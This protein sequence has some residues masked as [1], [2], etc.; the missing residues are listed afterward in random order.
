MVRSVLS[1]IALFGVLT[2][3]G[4][5]L[6]EKATLNDIVVG[7]HRGHVPHGKAESSGPTRGY[8][9]RYHRLELTIDPAIREISGTVTTWF[10]AVE[11]IQDVAFDL[12][13]ELEVA[14][15]LHHGN[16]LSFNRADHVLTVQLPGLL[17]EG[18]LDSLT[19]EYAGVPPETGF[20]SFVQTDHAG[21][22]VIWTLSEPYG[23]RDWW[24]CKQDLND[25]ADSLDV[26]VTV[27]AGQRVASNGLL[28]AE[29]PQGA[30]WVRHRWVHRYP[31]NYY[32]VAFAVTNYE[33]Y[34]DLVPLPE[35]DVEVLNYVYPEGLASAQQETPRLI[36]Q[37]QLFN[38]LFGTYPFIN[39][40]YGHAQFSWGGGM[41]H[42]TM[43]FMG[44]FSYELMAHE[45]A[46]QWFG[47]KVTCGSWEDIWLNEGFA[48]YLSGLCYEYLEP[49][50]WMPFKRGRR[51]LV[52]SQPGGSVRCMDTTQVSSIFNGRL[53]YAKGAFLVHMLRWVTGDSAFYAGCR[54]YLN[55]PELA[56]ASAVTAELQAHLEASS[57]VDLDGFMADWYAGEG[58]P[59]YSAEWSQ[60]LDGTV[61]LQLSQSTSHPSVD[62]F[63][64]P[65]PIHFKNAIWDTV[66]VVDH[67]FSGQL[68]TLPLPYQVDS[69]L[70]DPDIWILSGQNVV[71]RVPDT[72]MGSD[73]PVLFP[74]PASA[75]IQV[76]LE[77]TGSGPV[78]VRVMDHLGRLVLEQK[79]VVRDG[80]LELA[81]HGFRA[82][83]YVLHLRMGPTTY[84][85]PFVKEE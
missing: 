43:S 21:A 39:E 22:P 13:D 25:K 8:D 81:V 60:D 46:H 18:E 75:T 69:A 66:V 28:E 79:S 55:D 34:S 19:I 5:V 33:A 74:N 73:R 50:W 42:Q 85:L 49:V 20:G 11:P 65:V 37:M 68:F 15:V 27:P 4:Q 82:G 10:T 58:Y 32:L 38:A 29:E 84:A 59:T 57:G 31:I 51:D 40:K 14:Q 61:A 30:G 44:G 77:N 56:H 9:V 64:M 26:W 80:L 45:L 1:V 52:I 2:A 47:N 23:A 48:T 67:N 71:T 63:E 36:A 3:H 62:F 7:E 24:P 12:R 54:N 17:A 70:I 35:G 53:S 78:E 16:A 6:F 76:R 72:A 41:E 83:G